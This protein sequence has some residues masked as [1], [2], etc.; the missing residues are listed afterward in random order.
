MLLKLLAKKKIEQKLKV[1][2]ILAEEEIY[3]NKTFK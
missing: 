2:G 1:K 3:W